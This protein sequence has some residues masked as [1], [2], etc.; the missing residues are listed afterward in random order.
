MNRNVILK[1]K[2]EKRSGDIL[3]F[4]SILYHSSIP[5]IHKFTMHV[6]I[7]SHV[8]EPTKVVLRKS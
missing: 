5:V 3:N 4:N 1:R 8:E 6:K 7:N 2:T